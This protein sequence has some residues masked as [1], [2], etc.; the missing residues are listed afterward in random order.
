MA[1]GVRLRSLGVRVCVQGPGG[2]WKHCEGW[3][4]DRE[5]EKVKVLIEATGC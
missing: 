1:L 5:D 3:E 2:H 4:E